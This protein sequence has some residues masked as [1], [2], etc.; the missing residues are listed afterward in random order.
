MSR[1][2]TH[3]T[4]PAAAQ[5]LAQR[6]NR[7]RRLGHLFAGIGTGLLGAGIPLLIL[8]VWQPTRFDL[9][10]GLG[11]SALGAALGLSF[12]LG[13]A[14]EEHTTTP[15]EAAWAL[16]RIA[17][18]GERGLT[19]ATVAGPRG[20]EAAFAHPPLPVPALPR[21][22]P[23]RGLLALG[24][25]LLVALVH[26]VLPTGPDAAASSDAGGMIRMPAGAPGAA[27]AAT[28]AQRADARRAERAAA[29][30]ADMLEALGLP[31]DDAVLPSELAR[32]L[33]DPTRKAAAEA[34]ADNDPELAAALAAGTSD[35]DTLA[36][37]LVRARAQEGEAARLRRAL[38][39]ATALEPTPPLALERRALVRR[40]FQRRWQD[41]T[42]SNSR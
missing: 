2:A 32:R 29:V 25:G 3:A 30:S 11:L 4:W 40:Y 27:T 28:D 21:L 15:G 1:G 5:R 38:S 24:A 12:G 18:A 39:A 8:R 13:K 9:G 10:L 36:R 35:P 20:A 7:R 26:V 22:L 31:P 23:P 16:D 17:S 41:P 19:A 34:A 33:D 37:S 14:S 6:V 42:E